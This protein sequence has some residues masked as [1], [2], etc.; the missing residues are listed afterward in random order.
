VA[1]RDRRKNNSSGTGEGVNAKTAMGG[2]SQG[3]GGAHLRSE[4]EGRFFQ[5]GER[6]YPA[7]QGRVPLNQRAYKGKSDFIRR[8]KKEELKKT[9][10]K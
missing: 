2:E 5:S 8:R 7:D 3:I 4:K 10:S 6:R 1:G 9:F